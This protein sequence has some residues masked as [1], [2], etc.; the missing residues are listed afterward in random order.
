MKKAFLVLLV[1]SALSFGQSFETH[2]LTETVEAGGGISYSGS[3]HGGTNSEFQTKLLSGLNR[4][5][6][7]FGEYS[8]SQTAAQTFYPG[9]VVGVRQSNMEM[10]GGVEVHYSGYRVQPYLLTGLASVRGSTKYFQGAAELVGSY[11]QFAY[12]LG[13]GV[14]IFATNHFGFSAEAK[15]VRGTGGMLFNQFS[16]NAFFQQA[17]R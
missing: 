8:Y 10:G 12:D 4:Y 5:L 2:L 7:L 9:P 14:R 17:A 1:G 3:Y 11:Y 16:L 15:T 13:G 6:S